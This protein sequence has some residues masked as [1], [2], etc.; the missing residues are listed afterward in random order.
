MGAPP[1]ALVHTRQHVAQQT[2]G[3]KLNSDDDQ[4]HPEHEQGKAI[5]D[6]SIFKAQ[7]GDIGANYTTTKGRNSAQTPE[8]VHGRSHKTVLKGNGQQIQKS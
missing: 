3:K 5:L 4:K 8:Y 6:I 7:K 2:G 1:T